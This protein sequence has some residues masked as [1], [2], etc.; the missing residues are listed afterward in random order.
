MKTQLIRGLALTLLALVALGSV[1]LAQEKRTVADLAFLAG[2]WR[3]P[4][5]SGATAEE[6]ISAPEGGVMVS[7]GREFQ[8][9]KCVF[10]DLVVMME[11]DGGVVLIPHPNGKRSAHAFPLVKL[12]AAARRVTFENQANSFPKTFVYELVGPDHLRITLVGEQQGKAAT[13]VYDLRRAK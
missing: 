11:K 8:G 13:E 5:S 10:Y 1:A 7:A 6:L 4:S 3:G 9:G 12:E 2:S